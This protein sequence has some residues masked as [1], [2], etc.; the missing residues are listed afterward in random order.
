VTRTSHHQAD[1]LGYLPHVDGLRA[2]AVALVVVFHAWPSVLP[3]GFIGVD[4]FFVI[5]GFIITRQLAAEMESGGFSYLAF[6]GRRIRRLIPAAAVCCIL[7]AMAAAVILM[8]DALEMFSR[9]LVA[10]WGM[11]ANF[12]FFKET[13]YFDAPAAEAPLLHMWSLAVEDQFYLTWPLLLLLLFK[14]QWTRPQML[15]ALA[16]LAALSLA[17]SQ[18][19][20]THH[21][22]AAFFLPL[23]RAF[24]LLAG[25]A[26]AL[27]LPFL[28][29]PSRG[30]GLIDAAGLI[31]VLGSAVLLSGQ[32]PFPGFAAV[33][34]I[35]GSMLLI[36]TGLTGSTP[37]SRVLSLPP[38]L[39][40]GKMSYSIYL[41]HWPVLALATYALGR[42]PNAAEA[43]V[44]VAVAL[45]LAALSC[46]CSS[47][48]SSRARSSC[49]A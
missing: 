3:G 10:V 20:A 22:Q 39:L 7:T 48:R 42:A 15:V 6:L 36:G 46:G 23:S 9:S 44:L 43:G 41:Y 47:S 11:L 37:V 30:R 29:T 4:V 32:T 49:T 24:E 5:S 1:H 33:P 35:V 13:G 31:L 21:P 45:V 26:L 17:H 40:V 28:T 14:R 34:A 2:I 19:A 27:A 18:H 25:C 38:V 12:Y 8:P 16:L